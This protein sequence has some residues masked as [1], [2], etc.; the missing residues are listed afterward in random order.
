MVC[1][2]HR[3]WSE[4]FANESAVQEFQQQRSGEEAPPSHAPATA[5]LARLIAF[6]TEGR[7]EALLAELQVTFILAAVPVTPPGRTMTD[8]SYSLKMHRQQ[9]CAATI[10]PHAVG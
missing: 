9:W 8:G 4:V 10:V 5:L 1:E 6:L 3:L 7:F 2:A